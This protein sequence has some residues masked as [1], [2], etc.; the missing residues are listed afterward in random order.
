MSHVG[1]RWFGALL[2]SALAGLIAS[3]IAKEHT[4][5]AATAQEGT[6]RTAIPMLVPEPY[7][8]IDADLP[9]AVKQRLEGVIKD[10]SGRAKAAAQIPATTANGCVS[11]GLGSGPSS[12]GAPAPRIDARILGHHVEVVFDFPRMPQSPACRPFELAVVVYSGSKASPT[13]KNFVQ[14][15]WLEGSRGRV[16]LDLPW[17]GRAPYHVLVTAA[18]ILGRRGPAVEQRLRCPRT[19]HAVRGCLPGYRPS[20]HAYPMPAPVLPVRGVERSALEASLRYALAGEQRAP[21]VNA[22]PRSSRCPT[23]TACIVTYVDPA[24]PDSAYRVRYRIAGQQIRGCWMAMRQGPLDARPF[25][26]AFTG[27]LELAACASWVG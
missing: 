12:L 21:I 24:F 18:T 17:G 7:L 23:L 3:S 2:A 8:S 27:R 14:R 5:W 13:F 9:P 10:L 16:A 19:G 20:A 26:D 6:A 11:S 25:S 22:V 15:Y 4:S 1:T